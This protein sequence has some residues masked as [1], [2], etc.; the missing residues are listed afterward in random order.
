MIPERRYNLAP[1]DRTGLMFGLDASQL[2]IIGMGCFMSIMAM[3]INAPLLFVLIPVAV[4]FGLSK[5]SHRGLRLV[6][7]LRPAWHHF[8]TSRSPRWETATPWT[9]TE[10]DLP[11]FLSRI[12]I[13]TVKTRDQEVAVIVDDNQRSVAAIFEVKGSDFK[14]LTYGQQQKLL[15]DWG[16]VIALHANEGSSV[17]RIGWTAVAARA[18]LDDHLDYLGQQSGG[19]RTAKRE[20]LEMV[21]TAGMESTRHQTFV[22]IVV[23]GT[24]IRSPK[25]TAP[26]ESL[27]TRAITECIDATNGTIAALREQKS[28]DVSPPLSVDQLSKVMREM[29]DP[30]SALKMAPKV[31]SL[32]AVLG[33]D[34]T[35]PMAPSRVDHESEWCE[36][37]GVFHRSYWVEEWPRQSLKA[38]WMTPLLSRAERARRM[39]VWFEPVPVSRSLKRIRQDQTKLKTDEV[40]ADE[41]SKSLGAGHR[42]TSE[43]TDL[44]EDELV[45]GYAETDYAGIVTLSGETL[46]E[47]HESCDKFRSNA[48]TAGLELRPLDWSQDL[49]WA[50]S[51]PLGIS[52][53]RSNIF[54]NN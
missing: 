14:L 26:T 35:K 47:L 11:R 51:L 19:P 32:A 15:D 27:L 13:K 2:V 31:G 52:M 22:T 1:L 42:R 16:S 8:C 30:Q 37:D 10:G 40:V 38:S 12:R 6:D 3:A 29:I 53:M 20:Y 7:W 28:L 49:G 46:E 5:A 54:T 9:G 45:D 44:R 43:A 33:L 23:D 39:T 4:G 34:E 50:A 18:S 24:R 17:V 41:R 21:R 36:I 25:W 48:L